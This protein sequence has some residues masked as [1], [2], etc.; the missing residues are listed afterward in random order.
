MGH[1]GM[2]GETDIPADLAARIDWLESR[3]QIED[4]V[5]RYT[6]CV[7]D[8]REG[9]VAGL[10]AADAW[11]ELHH[12]DALD[13]DSTTLHER[14]AGKEAIL[15][16]FQQVA[17]NDAVVWPMIHNLRIEIE[18]DTARSRCVMASSVRPHGFQYVGE[19]H[20]TFRREHG[21]W[22]FASRIF[23]GV[24]AMEGGTSHDAH[25]GW[26]DVKV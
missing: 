17:G 8:R 26:Q 6:E 14:F 15:G 5:H 4:L 1:E 13:P 12:G 25:A 20:D 18:G 22:L 24:G 21:R 2:S 11:V 7:R 10:M 23:R 3:A 16:S 19:Y 9:E